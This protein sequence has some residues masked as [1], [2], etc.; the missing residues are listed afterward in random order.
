ML[1]ITKAKGMIKIKAAMVGAGFATLK[2][3]CG[4]ISWVGV[5]QQH[6]TIALSENSLQVRV[7]QLLAKITLHGLDQCT[8]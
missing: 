3:S 2:S 5:S 7:H 4:V 8:W 1:H 6:L